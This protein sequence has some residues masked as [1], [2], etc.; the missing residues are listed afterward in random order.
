MQG[1]TDPSLC[2][3]GIQRNIKPQSFNSNKIFRR[4]KLMK[5]RILLIG[6][7]TFCVANLFAKKYWYGEATRQNGTYKYHQEAYISYQLPDLKEIVEGKVI[8]KMADEAVAGQ[9]SLNYPYEDFNAIILFKDEIAIT[10]SLSEFPG[11][12]DDNGNDINEW[13]VSVDYYIQEND[14]GNIFYKSF[15]NFNSALKEFKNQRN[16]YVKELEKESSK[17]TKQST[18]KKQNS[19][20]NGKT[21]KSS[22][23]N[24]SSNE[25]FQRELYRLRH[26]PH[27]TASSIGLDNEIR[28]GIQYRYIYYDD[29]RMEQQYFVDL[30]GNIRSFHRD[31]NGNYP[32][33][34]YYSVPKETRDAAMKSLE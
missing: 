20:T 12:I 34:P 3:K 2:A 10:V 18:T 21:S 8:E 1:F 14:K 33:L 5:K 15:N 26:E 30:D 16:Q 23:K 25:K 7:I 22:K 32:I 4:Y 19:K 31:I 29:G 9:G 17:E 11:D 13:E 6:L 24:T 28:R 27:Q